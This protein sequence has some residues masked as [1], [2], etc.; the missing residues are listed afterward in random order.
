MHDVL[1]AFTF[2]DPDG[3]GVKDTYGFSGAAAATGSSACFPMDCFIG[4]FGV[5]G[6]ANGY[7][8]VGDDGVLHPRP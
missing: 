7:F 3:N 6:V 2:N 5:T 8:Y 1:Y 4:S